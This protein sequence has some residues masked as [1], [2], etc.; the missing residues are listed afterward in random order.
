MSKRGKA[1][2]M[3]E[4]AAL[5]TQSS[6]LV[7][8]FVSPFL[9]ASCSPFLACPQRLFDQCRFL[10]QDKG[11]TVGLVILPEMPLVVKRQILRSWRQR[12]A[13]LMWGSPGYRAWH[14][15][16][17]LQ[18]H[19]FLVP[20]P[21]AVVEERTG[22]CMVAS[23][24]LSEGLVSQRPLGIYWEEKKRE[25]PLA[26]RRAFLLALALFL[27]R[28]HAAG[29]YSGDMKDENI[30][31]GEGGPEAGPE[32]FD[33]STKLRTGLR[34]AQAQDRPA[35]GWSFYLV[36]L[37]RV[38]VYHKLSWQR[39][40]KNL[41]QL[42]R[43]LGRKASQSQ[44]LFFLHSYMGELSL[45]RAQW[46]RLI[47]KIL[48]FA[49]KKDR[50][51]D[52]R[53]WQQKQKGT[54]LLAAGQEEGKRARISCCIISFNEEKNIRRCLE[55]VKWCDE[56]VVV[57]SFSTDC[58]V[59][60]CR[61]YTDRVL[62]RQWP[63]YVEQKRFALSQATYEWVLNVDADEEVSPELEQEIRVA[64]VQNKEE[65]DGFYIPRLVYYLGRWWWRGWYPGYRLRLFRKAKVRWGGVDPHEKV[66]LQGRAGRFRSHLYHYTYKDIA[67]HLR[68]L[69][70]LTEVAAL[71]LYVRGKR[72][73]FSNLCLRPMWRFV[74]VYFLRGCF[75][76][77]VPGFFVAATSAFY[78]FLKYAKLWERSVKDPTRRSGAQVGGRG[79][80]GDGANDL[81]L[82]LR[83]QVRGGL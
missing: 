68:A 34:Q 8:V 63:G 33:P 3:T 18:T 11:K 27:R 76:E 59:A 35:E 72:V 6:V 61:E 53:R 47:T 51:Y 19:G 49:A 60:I 62:Q 32:P 37:E 40:K 71:E 30:L 69:N 54:T 50:E 75:L 83:P 9:P 22:G 14:G 56:I 55:S 24:Y 44:R 57:D 67:D 42:D 82:P 70:S 52:K 23:Y 29:L 21:L 73:S 17:L 78:V 16:R 80:S 15:A 39:R 10:K 5:S 4:S 77:G 2:K 20:Q 41:V 13:A 45:D 28:F 66:I 79:G 46:H 31:V 26:R 43:T 38:K 12:F 7:T 81:S 1:D 36:D 64:L 25:W 58:T 74:R 48:R 65:V